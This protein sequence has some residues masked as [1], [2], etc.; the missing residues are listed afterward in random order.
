M[1]HGLS[2][3]PPWYVARP[4]MGLLAVAFLVLTRQRLGVVGGYEELAARA[5]SRRM[6]RQLEGR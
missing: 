2:T 3:A 5:T 4:A 6:V 1:R